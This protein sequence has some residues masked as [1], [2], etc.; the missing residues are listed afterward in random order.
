MP[1]GALSNTF[2]LVKEV[3]G[4][5]GLLVRCREDEQPHLLEMSCAVHRQAKKDGDK[6]PAGD[7]KKTL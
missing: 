1:S 6:A 3:D 4:A 2:S 7:D 5:W